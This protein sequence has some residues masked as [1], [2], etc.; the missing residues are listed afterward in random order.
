MKPAEGT[1]K[2]LIFFYSNSRMRMREMDDAGK[3]LQGNIPGAGE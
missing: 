2:V 3:R 1:G